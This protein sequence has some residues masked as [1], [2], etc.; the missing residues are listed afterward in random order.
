MLRDSVLANAIYIKNGLS[1]DP[2]GH[3]DNTTAIYLCDK[4]ISYDEALR[5]ALDLVRR[6]PCDHTSMPY[7]SGK[8]NCA[9][10][11][12]LDAISASF[13]SGNGKKSFTPRVEKAF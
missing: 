9:R 11:L 3:L 7:G 4:I 5:H 2:S 12:T 13:E 10:C 6:F 1:K 8:H